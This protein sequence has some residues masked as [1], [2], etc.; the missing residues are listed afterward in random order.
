MER[1]CAWPCPEPVL[2]M[3]VYQYSCFIKE[4]QA[5]GEQGAESIIPAQEEPDG[6]GK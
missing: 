4:R 5:E 1:W 6:V 3:A 2:G